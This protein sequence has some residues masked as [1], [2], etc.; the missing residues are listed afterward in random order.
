MLS[1]ILKKP[2]IQTKSPDVLGV[3]T[4][5]IRA[6]SLLSCVNKPMI[7]VSELQ[8]SGSR[9]KAAMGEGLNHTEKMWKITVLGV[10][11][12]LP[13]AGADFLEYGGNTSCIAVNCMGRMLVLDAGSGLT[14]LEESRADKRLDILL[15]HVHL[16][17]V[18][19]LPGLRALQDRE[20]QI[21]LYGEERYGLPFCQQIKTLFGKPYWPVGIEDFSARLQIHET[22]PDRR[23]ILPGEGGEIAVST[24]RGNHP[25]QSLLY[26]IEAGGKSLVYALDCEMNGQM[27]RALTEFAAGSGLII[28]DANFVSDDIRRG[29]GH[30]TWE[31]GLA[32]RR[33]AGAK[34]ILMTHY[35][36]GY[37]DTFLQQQERL[38][39]ERDSACLFA[40][41]GMVLEL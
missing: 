9:Q 28:W 3:C 5:N 14:L 10:R 30:S 37:T 36:W 29:W 2:F 15:T 7:L 25:D 39:R 18:I 4:K 41:E 17:H 23:F 13:A 19:G 1:R 20:A 6:W 27:L 26:R 8:E 21:H 33:A 31:E 22:G 34:R 12:S 16:D 38:A 40:R 32:L 24:L 11:G 35:S